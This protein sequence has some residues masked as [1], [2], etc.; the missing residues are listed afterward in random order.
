MLQLIEEELT[1]AIIGAFYEVYNILGYG[2]LEHVYVRAME[3]ELMARGHQVGREV[4]VQISYK[5]QALTSQRLDMVVDERV[6]VELKASHD[7]P[8]VAKRQVY[9]YLRATNLEVGLLLHFGPNAKFH[10]LVKPNRGSVGT[11]AGHSV[12]DRSDNSRPIG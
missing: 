12:S 9:N 10:R 6:V 3:E 8:N 4:A 7:L 5:S 2:F 1:H 11:P